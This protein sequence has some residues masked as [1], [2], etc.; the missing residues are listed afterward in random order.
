MAD[1]ANI[2]RGREELWLLVDNAAADTNGAWVACSNFRGASVEISEPDGSAFGSAVTIAGTHG[3]GAAPAATVAGSSL[4]PEAISA[5]G[6][7]T[8]PSPLP[9]FIK[10]SVVRT[11]NKCRVVLR[12]TR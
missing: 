5:V 9:S 7:V 10:A 11:S 8:I 12:L 4:L 3:A 6:I 2:S 1:G